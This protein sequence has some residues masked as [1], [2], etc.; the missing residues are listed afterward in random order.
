VYKP[1]LLLPIKN[2]MQGEMKVYTYSAF[3]MAA[4]ATIR[5]SA[6]T[7]RAPADRLIVFLSAISLFA[8]TSYGSSSPIFP[9]EKFS[10][11]SMLQREKRKN[12]LCVSVA[13]G[14]LD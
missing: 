10:V 5:A 6:D 11:E 2:K 13:T 3:R 7:I 4:V 9:G 8:I 14:K 1:L 12:P